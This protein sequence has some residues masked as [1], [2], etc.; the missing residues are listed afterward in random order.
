MVS[1]NRAG[2]TPPP[3]LIDII[4]SQQRDGEVSFEYDPV[5]GRLSF[6]TFIDISSLYNDKQLFAYQMAE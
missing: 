3:V 1:Y 5:S 4:Y 6:L 2:D